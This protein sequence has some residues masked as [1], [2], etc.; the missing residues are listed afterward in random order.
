MWYRFSLVTYH[1][2][3]M[4]EMLNFIRV[5]HKII[6]FILHAYVFGTEKYIYIY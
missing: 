1:V 2:G 6:Y 3:S 4:L 5:M